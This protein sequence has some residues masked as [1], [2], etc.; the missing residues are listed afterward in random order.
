[1]FTV[2]LWLLA[3]LVAGAVTTAGDAAGVGSGTALRAVESRL[4]GVATDGG[5]SR[6]QLGHSH[7][8]YLPRNL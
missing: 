7:D 8:N 6:S 3:V 2:D 1:M 5:R 4:E